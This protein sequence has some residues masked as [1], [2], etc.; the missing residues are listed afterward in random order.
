[1]AASALSR[2]LPTADADILEYLTATVD[3]ALEDGD[4]LAEALGD[5][6]ISYEL[7]GRDAEQRQ[8]AV[9]R[10]ETSAAPAPPPPLP[11]IPP[12]AAADGS[13]EADGA[14]PDLTPLLGRATTTR[15]QRRLDGGARQR[16]GGAKEYHGRRRARDTRPRPRTLACAVGGDGSRAGAARGGRARGGGARARGGLRAVPRRRRAAARATSASS[17]SCCSPGG[18]ALLEE[19]A[20]LKLAEGRRYGLVGRNGTGKSTLSARSV[21][22]LVGFPRHLKAVHV[23]QEMSHDPD[24]TAIGTVLASDLERRVL[25]RRVAEL[26]AA[27]AED[28][29]RPPAATKRRCPRA[30]GG[31]GWRRRKRCR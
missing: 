10:A 27:V 26:S 7:R 12:E 3:T 20:A 1:M 5:L 11:P 19:G 2:L 4:D 15:R 31:S 22:D 17:R 16:R 30:R 24:A 23:E 29:R 9:R 14:A 28:G 8:P 13:F 6:L 21:V 18:K 25:K